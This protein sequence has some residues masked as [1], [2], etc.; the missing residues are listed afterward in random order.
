M[1]NG[2][3]LGVS[4]CKIGLEEGTYFLEFKKNNYQK[5]SKS[6]KV[7][8]FSR[9]FS[10]KLR[11]EQLTIQIKSNP[12]GANIFLDN[13]I[14]GKSNMSFSM[15][16]GKYDLTL[17]KKGFKS[18]AQ[19][20]D[21]SEKQQFAIHMEFAQKRSKGTA[22]LLSAV[23]PG[24]G[25]SYMKRG[26]AAW[27]S[28]FA[29]YGLAYASYNKRVKAVE[30]YK[31]YQ[32]ATE[33]TTRNAYLEEAEAAHSQSQMLMYGAVGT[34]TLNMIWTFAL[35]SDSKRMKNI[36]P[37]ANYNTQSGTMDYGLAIRW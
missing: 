15:P 30:A 27:L 12:A 23:W 22:F 34:W 24:A 9:N 18:Y 11:G 8:N 10:E 16:A 31:N 20:V 4:P 13:Q 28:G 26:G 35:P 25:Q 32:G 6:I 29:V 21:F 14:K 17:K 33:I 7:T 36:K 19:T 2:Q 37:I 3:K 1:I 5:A